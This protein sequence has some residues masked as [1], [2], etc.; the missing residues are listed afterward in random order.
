MSKNYDILEMSTLSLFHT[1][2]VATHIGMVFLL[3]LLQLT[4]QTKNVEIG[5]TMLVLQLQKFRLLKC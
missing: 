1:L 3:V 2:I 5:K 4:A